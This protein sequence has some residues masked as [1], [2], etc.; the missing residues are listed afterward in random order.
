MTPLLRINMHF[1]MKTKKNCSV[2][3]VICFFVETSYAGKIIKNNLREV[4][5]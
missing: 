3:A 2:Y 1:I 5:L 4:L